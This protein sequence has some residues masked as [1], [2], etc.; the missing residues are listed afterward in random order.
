VSFDGDGARARRLDAVIEA[1]SRR[2]LLTV[3]VVALVAR[4]AFAIGSFV[5]NHHVLIPDEQQYIDLARTVAHGKT[6][7]TWFPQYGQSLYD[8][9]WAFTA[10][11]RLLFDVFTASR[12]VGQ[13]L[14]A[15]FGV[16]TAVLV[17]RL[18]REVVADRVALAAGLVAAA[19][20]SQVL[21][22]SVV[23]RESMVWTGLMIGAVA[24]TASLRS[25]GRAAAGWVALSAIGFLL[26]GRLRDQTLLAAVYATVPAVLIAAPD[27]R[28][29]RALG[30]VAL[31][32]AMP[33]MTGT[34]P[35]GATLIADRVPALGRLRA[36]LASGA[37]SAFTGTTLAIP[38]I[39]TTATSLAIPTTTTTATSS[40]GH[41]GGGKRGR[42]RGGI[43]SA[44]ST[45]TTITT[46]TTIVL[47]DVE[48][49]QTLVVSPTGQVYVVEES[50]SS[51]LRA[52]PRGAVAV[53]LRP[54]LWESTGSITLRFAAAEN[55]AWYV[56]YALAILGMV[57]ADRRQRRLLTYPAVA[58]VAILLVAFVTQANLGT[59]FRHRA[60]V[61]P[62]M[63]VPASVGAIAVVERLRSRRERSTAA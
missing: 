57:V 24:I 60:Q 30:A 62:L 20:P 52:I 8:S 4:L 47:P 29:R 42:G 2:P 7:E 43:P 12:L 1:A 31:V 14:A 15:A 55:L 18:A 56:L 32:V 28:W 11:L 36:N 25:R 10:P 22:S 50:A 27:H 63:V 44:S 54:F 46:T 40:R 61:L 41:P 35:A 6:A 34:G 38:T 45:T 21:W 48:P 49:G 26:V 58:T 17:A 53:L 23:L 33:W 59:A 13:L 3:A 39:T 16:V 37:D 5:L 51:N 19:V 9:T